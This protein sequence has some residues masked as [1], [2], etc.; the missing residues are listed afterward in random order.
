MK[1]NL[2]RP[3]FYLVVLLI[4]SACGLFTTYHKGKKSRHFDGSRFHNRAP[5]PN[6]F[7]D[8]LKWKFSFSA[9]PWPEWVHIRQVKVANE[10]VYG[11][12]A[13]FTFINHST[14]LIQVNGANILTDPV[15]SERVSPYKFAGPK[16]HKLP[17]VKIEDLPPIDIILISHNHYD[18]LDLDTLMALNKKQEKKPIILIG[19]GNEKLL[20]E[21]G[22]H[23][24]KVLDWNDTFKREGIIYRFVECQHWSSRGL[25]DKNKTLWGSFI[26]DY[27]TGKF[28][29]AGDSGYFAGFKEHGQKYGPFRLSLLPIGAYEPRWFMKFQHMDPHESVQA[30][31]DL[32][33]EYAIGIHW[34]TFQLT[35]EGIDKPVRDLNKELELAGIPRERFLYLENGE[36]FS[37]SIE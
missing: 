37:I 18:H 22:I 9:K 21:E 30:F 8:L 13:V 34:G 10:R 19:P 17:G 11:E 7:F 33:S 32:R 1:V 24:F 12:K 2:K 26:I 25:F 6:S 23:N 15:W 5:F 4:F 3:S 35:D 16:R 28:F 31:K 20:T 29:F 36:S 14:V 27:G